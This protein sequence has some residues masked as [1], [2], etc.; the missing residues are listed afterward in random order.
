MRQFGGALSPS[1]PP[2][3]NGGDEHKSW[4]GHIVQSSLKFGT[5]GLRGLAAELVGAETRRYV[6]AFLR[7]LEERGERPAALYLGYDFR[8]SSPQIKTDCA[9]AAAEFGVKAIQCGAV[10]TP[11][12]AFHAI[13]SGQPSVMVTGSHIPQD[14]NGLK[15]YTARGE[16]TKADELAIIEVLPAPMP[17]DY[18]TPIADHSAL[19]RKQYVERYANFLP[20]RSLRGMRIGVYEHSSVARDL[21]SEILANF[22]AE[23]VR[24]GRIDGFV[25]VDTEALSDAVF[26]PLRG[27]VDE[28]RL[29][30][31]VSTDGD[32]D[33]PMLMDGEGQFVPGDVLGLLTAI[34]VE[35]ETLVTP[36]TSNTAIETLG[37]FRDIR[38][39]RVG[40]PYVIA[41][42]AEALDEGA[43][44]V[45]GF[46]PNGG[47][48]LG[49]DITS[50]PIL[51][52]LMTRDALLPIL[53]ALGLAARE[54]TSIADLV[55]T[56]ALRATRSD[57]LENIS[58]AACTDFLN[59]LRSP[60]YAERYFSP[61]RIVR[62]AD[63][64]G[65][66]FWLEGGTMIHYR[67]SGN[68]PEL[69][70]YV[71]ADDDAVALAALEW[72]LGAARNALGEAA[73]G[74]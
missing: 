33:R 27:W 65:L 62:F 57:R 29:D 5:S 2:L 46:E 58:P 66:Q 34:F 4:V 45:V 35:A 8:D 55:D 19:V 41:A 18:L 42:M 40:S 72:G 3:L 67:G 17:G 73:D 36:V 28:Y 7:V 24:L 50:G 23:I 25:A 69:R 59:R 21:L 26:R 43:T 49:C 53:G 1:S 48:L 39:T 37:K 60:E 16:I 22:G 61:Q 11:A 15:F 70:C 10:P 44:N 30:A 31:I 47:T 9:A 51:S 71:E 56:L 52:R 38:R 6:T 64:D 14:R 32:A 54:E 63:I 20:P 12:L 68:A 13:A 74:A